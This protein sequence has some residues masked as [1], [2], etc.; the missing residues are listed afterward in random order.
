MNFIGIEKTSLING[1]GIRIVLWVSGCNHHCYNCQNPGTWD[2]DAGQRFYIKDYW[3]IRE[4]V[5]EDYCSGLT[6][7]GGDPMYPKNRPEILALCK[8][9]RT[10][11]GDKK[12]IWM[13]TGY[14]FDEIKDDPI[15]DY[16]DVIVDGPY[17]EEQRN[18]NRQWCGSENQRIWRKINNEWICEEPKYAE[19]IESGKK[20]CNL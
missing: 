5:K 19:T 20:E 14:T 9:F 8:M 2:E 1:D 6:L 3:I 4:R 12:T 11:F 18:I 13:Y 16:I 10:D 15:L 17:I 7:S